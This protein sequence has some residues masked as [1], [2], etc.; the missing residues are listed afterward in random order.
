MTS[1]YAKDVEYGLEKPVSPPSKVTQH[2]DSA[3]VASSTSHIPVDLKEE[4]GYAPQLADPSTSTLDG[5]HEDESYPEGGRRAYSVVF[6]SFCG[7]LAGFGLLNTVGTYQAYVS[8]HQLAHYS[9]SE[10]GWIF[11]LYAFLSF[12]C[13]VQIGPVFD[14][15]GPRWLV[16]AGSVFLVG[17]ML[18]VA[19]STGMC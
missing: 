18:G 9:E 8:T 19:N 2:N 13:G 14:A 16:F 7:M 5:C 15:K 11:G 4:L 10:V 6:G 12:F 1:A 3:Q 17:G